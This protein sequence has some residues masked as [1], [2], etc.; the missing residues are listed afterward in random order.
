MVSFKPF[1]PIG[2]IPSV[3]EPL[4]ILILPSIDEGFVVILAGE[5]D[6]PSS[7]S[8]ANVA[9]RSSRGLLSGLHTSSSI[10]LQKEGELDTHHTLHRLL[11]RP[12]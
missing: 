4:P 5:V 12:P 2:T 3:I 9:T 7:I 8:G 10:L 1:L 11:R 6:K